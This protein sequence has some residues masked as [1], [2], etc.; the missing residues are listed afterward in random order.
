M[1]YSGAMFDAI[2]PAGGT[3][4]PEFAQ[5]VGTSNKAL[6]QFEG[7]TILERVID[8][9]RASGQVRR[10]AV[11]G[12]DEVRAASTGAD[13]ILPQGSTGP[14]NILRGLEALASQPDPPS[15]VLVV[16]TDLPFLTPEIVNRFIDQCPKD[17][18]ITVPLISKTEFQQRFPGCECSF[19]RLRDD[20]WTAGCMYI[21]DVQALRDAKPYI[22]KIFEV[23]KSKVGMAKLLGVGF[24]Y[25]FLTRTLTVPDVERK[26]QTMLHCTGKAIMHSPPELAYDIDDMSD[27][28][29][30]LSHLGGTA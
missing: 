18:A 24:L 5:Q 14:D 8:A 9:L 10:I 27:Y 21:L 1:R 7:R 2:L 17:V 19:I 20:T 3:I 22:D 12:P 29:Y 23:R 16:T 28:Q 6:I 13:L 25:N 15:K 4:P 11:I 30:A 26:I